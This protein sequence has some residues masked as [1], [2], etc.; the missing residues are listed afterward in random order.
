MAIAIAN[1]TSGGFGTSP[2]VL[3]IPSTAAGNLLSVLVGLYIG[4]PGTLTGVTDDAGNTYTQAAG[5]RGTD[6]AASTATDIW[7]CP[8]CLAGATAVTITFT[9]DFL[10]MLTVYE[11]AGADTSPFDAAGNVSNGPS[12]T[13][14]VSVPLTTSG[15]GIILTVIDKDPNVA[16]VNAPY[17]LDS[18]SGHTAYHVTSG[19]VTSEAATFNL[20][21]ADTYCSSS[22]AYK[23][24]FIPSVSSAVA[25]FNP[26]SLFD[27]IG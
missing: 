26:G 17:T 13:A 4:S 18:G 3:A 21:G 23:A 10:G 27:V 11:L 25:C 20:S 8:L 15:A 6:S 16:S 19:A 5:A 12:T 14:A 2:T 7:E 1:Q 22:V 24:A 9:G